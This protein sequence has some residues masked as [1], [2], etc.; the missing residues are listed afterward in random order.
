MGF[1]LYQWDFPY[2]SD[3]YCVRYGNGSAAHHLPTHLP[4]YLPVYLPV[5]MVLICQQFGLNGMHSSTPVAIHGAL[6]LGSELPKI[7]ENKSRRS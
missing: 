4:I 7:N 6:V 3:I 2:V 5:F 1:P